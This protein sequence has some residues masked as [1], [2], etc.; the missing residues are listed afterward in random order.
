MFVMEHSN[1][2]RSQ[3]KCRQEKGRAS[4]SSRTTPSQ[5]MVILKPSLKG[6]SVCVPSSL[7]QLKENEATIS[8][9][10]TT[11]I[12]S[13]TIVWH[14]EYYDAIN[15]RSS[16]T[17]ELPCSRVSGLITTTPSLMRLRAHDRN[18][19]LGCPNRTQNGGTQPNDFSI[20]QMITAGTKEYGQR[21]STAYKTPVAQ[22]TRRSSNNRSGQCS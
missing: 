5:P 2:G 18:S 20:R 14:I 13:Q 22:A 8:P 6:N 15:P 1:F 7:T 4:T 3:R 10:S 11:E 19:S 21:R 9:H 16:T 12:T 17:A